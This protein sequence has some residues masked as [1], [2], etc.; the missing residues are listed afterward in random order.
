[1]KEELMRIYVVNSDYNF[2]ETGVSVT[3][4]PAIPFLNSRNPLYIGV[5]EGQVKRMKDNIKN[6]KLGGLSLGF[7]ELG[8]TQGFIT[9]KGKLQLDAFRKHD[10]IFF[11]DPSRIHEK[12]RNTYMQLIETVTNQI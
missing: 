8:G 4:V 5:K 1:M 7:W 10:V 9:K 12:Y 2:S 3:D 11:A 6:E